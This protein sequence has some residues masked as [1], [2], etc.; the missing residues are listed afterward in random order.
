MHSF[1]FP[2]FPLSDQLDVSAAAYSFADWFRAITLVFDAMCFL[3]ERVMVNG[4]TF[5]MDAKGV[6]MK[7]LMFFGFNN[8]RKQFEV[9]QVGKFLNLP[10]FLYGFIQLYVYNK[11]WRFQNKKYD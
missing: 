11:L 3:D 10:I 6:A 9:M 1:I 5:L 2:Q 8:C 4:I 7:H